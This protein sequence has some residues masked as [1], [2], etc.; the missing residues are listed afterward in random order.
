LLRD[1]PVFQNDEVKKGQ[2]ARAVL[3]FRDGSVLSIALKLKW[4]W[5]SMSM[6]TPAASSRY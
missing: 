3:R 1:L 5:T 6:A 2:D 4:C